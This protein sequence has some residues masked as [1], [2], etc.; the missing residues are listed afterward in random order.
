MLRLTV[1]LTVSMVL[2]LLIAGE[3]RGQLR[4]GLA[5]V[6]AEGPVPKA[7]ALAPEIEVVVA[8]P[9]SEPVVEVVAAVA[10]SPAPYVEPAREVVQAVDEP[11]FTLS[12]L[13]TEAVPGAAKAQAS[14]AEGQ[15]Y[16][17][18][19]SSVNVREAPS[20]E[21]SVLGKLGAGEAALVITDVD[22]EWAR[23][24]IQGDGM[25]GYVAMRFLSAD[26][27]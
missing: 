5:K 4:P 6:A 14:R 8:E 17:V 25:E 19:A 10:P 23:I 18:T 20:T 22:G 9:V 26:A 15:I 24:V 21:A 13:A 1:L 12:A 2:A 7:A 27:P 16:Y 11:V 3:D